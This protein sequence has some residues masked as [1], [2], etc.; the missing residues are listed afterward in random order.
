MANQIQTL[1]R[2]IGE[3]N[4]AESIMEEEGGEQR[5]MQIGRDATEGYEADWSS[6]S[7]QPTLP[8]SR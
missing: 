6:M 8:S 5:L 4:I 3:V 7:E 1:I 2:L